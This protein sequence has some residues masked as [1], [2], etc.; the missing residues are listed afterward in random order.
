MATRQVA[1]QSSSS[2]VSVY[3]RARARATNR[4][5][6]KRHQRSS[7]AHS[8]RKPY[9]LLS[10]T[11]TAPPSLQADTTRAALVSCDNRINSAQRSRA[12]SITMTRTSSLVMPSLANSKHVRYINIYC[13]CKCACVMCSL[14]SLR[15]HLLLLL[16]LLSFNFHPIT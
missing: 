2:R 4:A 15:L 11:H 1:H 3:A 13:F 7:C 14:C 12:T 6:H 5:T 10:A 16:F 9:I 8:Q